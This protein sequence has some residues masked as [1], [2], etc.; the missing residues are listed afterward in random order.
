MCR[1]RGL[2]ICHG[3]GNCCGSRCCSFR[4]RDRAAA[5]SGS[6]RSGLGRPRRALEPSRGAGFGPHYRA[7]KD[8]YLHLLQIAILKLHDLVE[9][10]LRNRQLG[11]LKN[12]VLVLDDCPAHRAFALLVALYTGFERGT[13][14]HQS[15]GDMVLLA[16]SSNSFR[17]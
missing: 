2:C 16:R 15:S 12:L 5:I 10:L 9:S 11:L 6:A 1:R 7:E 17:A 8:F 14:K 3:G 13:E 4:R